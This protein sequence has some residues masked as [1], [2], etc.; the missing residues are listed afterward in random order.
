[1]PAFLPIVITVSHIVLAA[2][3][4]PEFNIDPSCRVAAEAAVAPN[5][6]PDACKHDEL[7]A[8]SKLND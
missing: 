6:N 3:R 4:M 2:D 1:M 8:R 5:R 7:V